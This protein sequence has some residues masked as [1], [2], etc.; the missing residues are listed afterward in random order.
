[1]N[2]V[3]DPKSVLVIGNK[4]YSNIDISNILDT[5]DDPIRCNM[6]M[7][8]SNN[9]NLWGDIY[10][11]IHIFDHLFN[12]KFT[13]EQF[14]DHYDTVSE[15]HSKSFYNEVFNSTP[16]YRSIYHSPPRPKLYNSYL[17]SLGIKGFTKIPRAGSC[18]V[19]E[20]LLLGKKVY[21]S[22]FSISNEN[23][24]TYYHFDSNINEYHHSSF[25]E[26]R[27]LKELH[28]CG[29]IDI[30]LCFLLDLPKPKM[31][32]P[33]DLKPD[34]KIVFEVLDRYNYID[35]KKR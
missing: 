33:D 8:G 30:T 9:G 11:N 22:H 24:T 13:R 10:V 27:I 12:K 25:D 19:M 2:F 16:K 28:R 23:R 29:H 5:F 34:K 1:M 6:C 35:L 4:A 31:R 14:V 32:I 26:Y 3:P 17:K 7:P 21:L 20:Q 18:V 15:S